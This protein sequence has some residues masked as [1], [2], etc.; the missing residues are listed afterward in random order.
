MTER[1]FPW[2]ILLALV[3]GIALGVTYGWVI[4]PVEVFDAAPEAL[5]LDFKN[6]YRAVIAASYAAN[7]DLSRAQ[8]RLSLLG[9]ADSYQALSAQAQ[10]ALAAGESQVTVQQLAGLAAALQG[11]APTVTVTQIVALNPS[12]TKRVTPVVASSK[13]LTP[14]APIPTD[15][16]TPPPFYTATPRPTSTPIPP[17][18]QPFELLNQE[19]F[20]DANL[21]PG[22][23]QVITQASSRR[24]LP[25]IELIL[26]WVG[27]EEH[28]FTGLK[29]ELGNGYADFQMA[30]G[31]T[32][33]LR[34]ADG[35]TPVPGLTPP[36][37]QA[38]NGETYYGQVLVT[39]QRP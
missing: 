28:F 36:A 13:S 27:G 34:A 8:A 19:S 38:D 25:G 30:P 11:S 6:Q 33:T 17:P 12:P 5:R 31:V 37:C 22:L 7:G 3:I 20:C 4:S 14:D 32:Y 16:E 1:R 29:P 23:L 26:S 24:Q 2:E 9:D 39:L 35:G 21:L 10:Q 15:T 18:A